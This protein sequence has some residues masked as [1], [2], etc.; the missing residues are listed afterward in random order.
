MAS[1]S[2]RRDFL[3]ISAVGLAAASANAKQVDSTPQSRTGNVWTTDDKT[4]CSPAKPIQWTH[5]A[6]GAAVIV[7]LKP[8]V[9]RQSILGF[10]GAFTDAACFMMNRL[11]VDSRAKLLHE[12][13]HPAQMGLSVCRTCMGA[14]DYSTEVFSYDDGEPDPELARFSI[15]HDRKYVL[16]VLREARAL[17]PDL[18]LFSSP[19][20]PPGWM[21]AGGSML[22]GSMR[23]RYL[24][25][26]ADYFVK[27]LQGYAAEGAP[28][29]A[30][31]P[32]NEV[33]TD[34]DGRMPACIWP[35]EY[36][37]E[38]IKLLGP[39]IAEQNLSTKI[40]LL[41]HNYNLWG[42]ASCSLEDAGLRKFCNDVAW[43]GYVGKPE[44]MK[45]VKDEFPEVG[46]HW[47]EGGPDYTSPDYL[48]DWT[49]WT[50]VFSEAL[51]N[52]C[53]SITAWNLA[54]DEKGRPNIGPFPCGGVV[55][56]NSESLEVT[57]SGQFWALM[58]FSRFI[59]RGATCMESD[60]TDSGVH[61]TFL[62]NADG[63]NVVVVGNSGEARSVSLQLGH[64][65]A[66][67]PLRKNATATL[68]WR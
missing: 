28:V 40:W 30:I 50:K 53:E 56:I 1:E 19:W 39:K 14:S 35:Q 38:F 54:L 8:D 58:H 7:A 51:R 33:D 32:Q 3:K 24:R 62:Q 47:T 15:D 6:A 22:G 59:R 27:F 9:R 13:F 68:I 48:S 49:H 37:I 46:M 45:K 31:T 60:C 63:T 57:R 11:S 42:R 52:G 43:H 67:L 41:D 66:E 65:T 2:T 29:S 18:F 61:H 5:A 25:V 16:P 23:R 34:Q 4:K 36:E 44:M 26:Y 55:T 17:N 20:S 12:M 21:K 64:L 10:G